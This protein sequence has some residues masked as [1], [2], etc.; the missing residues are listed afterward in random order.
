MSNEDSADEL[1]DYSVGLVRHVAGAIEDF[2]EFMAVKNRANPRIMIASAALALVELSFKH[3]KPGEQDAAMEATIRGI[4]VMHSDLM[5]E[6]QDEA[7]AEA[8]E[9]KA[10]GS[11]Q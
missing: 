1:D 2:A 6:Q 11:V 5:R 3:S 4:R 7:V 10:R 9:A 8:E